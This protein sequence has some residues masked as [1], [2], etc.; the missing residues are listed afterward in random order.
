MAAECQRQFQGMLKLVSST[1]QWEA[2]KGADRIGIVQVQRGWRK[3][4]AHRQGRDR[5]FGSSG[6]IEHV[7]K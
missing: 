1:D 6:G 7:P 2:I 4:I 5:Q 3:A